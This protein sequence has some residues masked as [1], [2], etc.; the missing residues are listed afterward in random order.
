M[1]IAVADT[2]KE[3]SLKAIQKLHDMG[4]E[5]AMITGDNKR[6]AEAIAKQVGIDRVLSE[7]LPEDKAS[8]VKKLQDEG[9]KVAMV[10]DGINDAPALAQAD[11]GIAIGTGTEIAAE[12]ADVVLMQGHVKDVCAAID[13]SRI[14]FRRIRINYL[15]ALLYNS[16]GIPIAAGVF[17]P[18]VQVRLPPELAALAMALSSISVVLSSL[19]LKL[20]KVPKIVSE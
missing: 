7:V 14:I 3:N 12:A 18:I 13:L 1:G 2:V 10:G 9:R 19:A 6:T 8:E 11:V 16:L 15:W 4:I 17:Y 20:Y 5:V